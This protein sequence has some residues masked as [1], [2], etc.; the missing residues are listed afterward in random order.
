MIPTDE[1]WLHIK[2]FFGVIRCISLALIPKD[3]P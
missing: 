2:I 1:S 3:G